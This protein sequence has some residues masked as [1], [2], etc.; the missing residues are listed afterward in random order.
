MKI[1]F[2]W[3]DARL[4]RRGFPREASNPGSLEAHST[5]KGER[6]LA[7][8]QWGYCQFNHQNQHHQHHHNRHGH[9]GDHLS[10]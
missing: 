10:S 4:C 9:H 3:R 5:G 1:Q 2:A 8:A 7:G 6:T